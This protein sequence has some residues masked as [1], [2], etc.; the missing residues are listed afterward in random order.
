M[1]R[2]V[3]KLLIVGALLL[4][5][6]VVGSYA[7][8]DP[9]LQTLVA[10]HLSSHAN[11][12]YA[13][14]QPTKKTSTVHPKK[15]TSTVHPKKNLVRY[16]PLGTSPT[17][18]KTKAAKIPKQQVK[19]MI[20]QRVQQNWKLIHT[21]MG[22]TT[23]DKA[24]AFF[25][26]MATRES[27]LNASTETGGTE[28]AGFYNPGH[29]YGALQASVAAYVSSHYSPE[30]DVPQTQMPPYNL[31]TGNYYD[32]GIAM[33]MGIRHFL[34]YIN[35][36]KQYHGV[37]RLKHAMIGFSTGSI[38]I[39]DQSMVKSYDDEVAALAGWYLH[40]GHLQDSEVTWTGDPRVNR[41]NPWS[42]Y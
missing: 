35:E 31:S 30:Y 21:L 14:V 15:K 16:F 20:E 36:A 1:P 10:G 7:F 3:G 39:T 40:N 13:R 25:L 38:Q 42:W 27:T 32:P 28:T 5:L 29:C 9:A 41:K 17:V 37:D 33:Y 11:E 23:I 8:A 12:M 22:F 34:H 18:M 24:Y 6:G 2:L 26:G 19:L 4:E